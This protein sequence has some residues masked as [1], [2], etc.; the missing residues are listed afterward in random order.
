MSGLHTWLDEPILILL[1]AL[2]L[3]LL[4]MEEKR[5]TRSKFFSYIASYH[6]TSYGVEFMLNKVCHRIQNS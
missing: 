6:K 4:Y 1:A 5:L 2:F 3:H